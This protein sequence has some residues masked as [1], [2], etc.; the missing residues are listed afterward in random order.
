M[1]FVIWML[2]SHWAGLLLLPY[3]DDEV[4]LVGLLLLPHSHDEVPL[5]W[6]VVAS[7]FT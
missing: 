3:S 2:R 6:S 1:L 7:S 5:G 4:L